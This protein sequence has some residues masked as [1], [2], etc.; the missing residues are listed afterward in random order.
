MLETFNI[1]IIFALGSNTQTQC[2][3]F[4]Q[5]CWNCRFIFE[6]HAEA[7]AECDP[8][9]SETCPLRSAQEVL[10]IPFCW[11]SRHRKQINQTG[12]RKP[13]MDYLSWS[14]QG[15]VS[16]RCFVFYHR[17]RSRKAFMWK[18]DLTYLWP[19]IWPSRLSV[20]KYFA[21]VAQLRI[22]APAS[23]SGDLV[24]EVMGRM[25]SSGLFHFIGIHIQTLLYWVQIIFYNNYFC[26]LSGL[27]KPA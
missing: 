3:G 24:I 15:S 17:R 25:Q 10:G 18:A 7:R 8:V 23:F 11:R 20:S 12:K 4:K 22:P 2:C 14:F 21:L 27:D 26:V 5:K 19:H 9:T 16:H 13:P 6:P 1:Y